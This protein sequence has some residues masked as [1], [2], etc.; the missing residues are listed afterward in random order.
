MCGG[1]FG[2]GA[3]CLLNHG[4]EP[5]TVNE[6]DVA[7]LGE[8]FG[9]GRKPP[10]GD[11]KAAR[12]TFGSH[13]AVEFAHGGHAYFVGLPLFALYEELFRALDQDEVNAAIRAAPADFCH[14]VS[15]QSVG[16]ADQQLKLP[17]AHAV[18]GVGIACLR[19]LRNQGL[20]LFA[21]PG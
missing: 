19:H 8:V 17:P 10:R 1:R 2:L 3:P 11:D 7:P 15:L 6:F 13:D 14:A 5:G 20:A 9:I 4:K 18:Q 21:P 12:G 16:F